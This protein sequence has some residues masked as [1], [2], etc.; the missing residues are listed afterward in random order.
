M[1]T[2]YDEYLKQAQQIYAPQFDFLDQQAAATQKQAATS[3]NELSALYNALAKDILAQQPGINKNYSTGIGGVD[4]AYAQ[5]IGDINKMYDTSR[6]SQLAILKQLGIEQAAPNILQDNANGRTFIEQIMKAN[7]Q[8][9][10]NALRQMNQADISFN[11]ETSNSSR[12]A[13]VNQRSQIDKQ[14]LD[15]LNQIA[16]K[17]AELQTG[18]NQ[19]A[20]G[21]QSEAAKLAQQQAEQQQRQSNWQQEFDLRLAEDAAK[22]AAARQDTSKLDPMSQVNS[23]ALQLYGNPQSA[24]NAVSAL[25]DA[26]AADRKMGGKNPGPITSPIDLYDEVMARLIQA[27][28]DRAKTEG[29]KL[30]QLSALMYG[31]LHGK[32]SAY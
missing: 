3:K 14:L 26:W 17:R 13:G 32:G 2:A 30:S 21:M 27:N 25:L 5:G 7:Q 12:M 10:D 6:D 15:I 4:S 31:L 24:S 20:S 23:L 11:R 22:Q 9:T 29:G 19:T 28:G 1:T 8:G 16:G 18:V